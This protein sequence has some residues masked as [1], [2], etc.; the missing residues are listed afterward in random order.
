MNRTA[1][2]AIALSAVAAGSAH[3]GAVAVGAITLSPPPTEDLVFPAGDGD[4]PAS[5]NSGVDADPDVT[6]PADIASITLETGETITSLVGPASVGALATDPGGE[7]PGDTIRNFFAIDRPEVEGGDSLLGLDV[8]AGVDN[9]TTIELF[10]GGGLAGAE[11]EGNDVFLFDLFGDDS[12]LI[13]ALDANGDVIEG[14]GFA[15]NSGPGPNNF[16]TDDRV[17]FGEVDFDLALFLDLNPFGAPDTVIDDID[18]AGVGFDVEDLFTELGFEEVFGLLITGTFV[19]S[20]NGSLDLI[21]AAINT[22]AFSEI[23]LPG[24][25]LL[26]GSGLAGAAFAGRKR[27]RRA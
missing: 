9:A 1:L 8:S 25:A 12:I 14:T 27:R 2:A 21:A 5:A 20:G 4:I 22:E 10:F 19:N 18:I 15:I 26:F 11:G 13:E 16:G 23:P 7:G 3:A 17:D 6:G 24:A